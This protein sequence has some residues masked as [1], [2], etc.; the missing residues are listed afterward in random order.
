ML[1]KLV[2]FLA[3]HVRDTVP[4]DESE[5]RKFAEERSILI[6]DDHLHFL[7]HFGSVQGGRASIF[8]WYEGDFDFDAFSRV[9]LEDY[10]DMVLPAGNTYFG[11]D[12]VGHSLCVDNSTGGIFL[13]D[14]GDRF[15]LVHESIDGF[16][17]RCMVSVYGEV[18]FRSKTVDLHVEKEIF[19]EIRLNN[20]SK[21]IAG[22]T[23]F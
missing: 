10:P 6:R 13:Y 5:I 2:K 11:S 19:D 16:L 15:G 12:F 3:L 18:A 9:Y 4:V 21:K 1:K 17:L 22:S 23:D 7:M 14:E 8:G 20:L